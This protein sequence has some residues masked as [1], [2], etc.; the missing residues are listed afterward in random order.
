MAALD[1]P[2]SPVNGQVYDP[3]TGTLYRWNGSQWDVVT[4]PIM[5]I[6][7][8]LFT[9]NGTYVPD[10]AMVHCII[11]G[12]GGGG[13]GGGVIG[14]AG[15]QTNGSGGG[16]GAYSRKYATRAEIGASQ[17]VAVGAGAATGGWAAG[18]RGGD[19]AVGSLLYANGGSGGPIGQ[20]GVA[21][22][23]GG[24][25]GTINASTK[26]DFSIAGGDGGGGQGSANNFLFCG[27]GGASFFAG[28]R[29]PPLA[30][31]GTTGRSYGGGGSGAQSLGANNF[32]GGPGAS[33]VVIITEYCAT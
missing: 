22:S 7:Q 26:G 14:T 33:G 9:V 6:R 20:S 17:N 15:Q 28:E 25:G 30:A 16:G 8:Q 27:W 4:V 11:E 29:T 5:R 18:L 3:G 13:S 23:Q 24:A 12:V 2:A 1:F 19:T 21:I 32:S 10:P 31:N